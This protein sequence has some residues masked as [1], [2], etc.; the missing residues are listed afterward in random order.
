MKRIIFFITIWIGIC[1]VVTGQVSKSVTIKQSDFRVEK[2]DEYEKITLDKVHYTTDIVGHPELPVDVLSFVIPIDAQITG[3]NISNMSKQKLS[4]TYNIY[5]VQP[6]RPVSY[7]KGIIYFNLPDSAIYN[8]SKPY[9]D[10]YAEIISDDIY[11]GYRVV[12]VRSYPVEYVPAMRELYL[13]SFDFSIDY[14]MNEKQASENK[15]TTQT[16]SLYRYEKNKQNIKFRVEN[17]EVVDGYDTKVQKILQ[18]ETVVYDFSV[19]SNEKTDQPSKIATVSNTQT[20]DYIIITNNALKSSFQT[21]ANWKTRKGIFT[22]IVT[23][24]EIAAN[25]SGVDLQ[26]KIRNYLLNANSQWGAGLYVLLGGGIEIVP[27]RL[28]RGVY[29]S[30]SLYPSD[31]YYS[32]STSW[33][34]YQGN[35]YN[36]NTSTAIINLLG[37][38]PVNNA[39][40]VTIYTNKLITYEK[41]NNL[42]DLSYLKNNLYADAYLEMYPT[43]ELYNFFHKTIKDYKYTYVPS[44]INN[45]YLCDNAD[46]SGST[47]RYGTNGADCSNG[48]TN[49]DIEF[50]PDNFLSCLSTGAGL[51]VGKFHFIYHLDHSGALGLGASF[52]DKNKIIHALNDIEKI[53][54][55]TSYQIL[56]SSGC[57]PAD[58][59]EF[60]GSCFA[61]HHL[62]N[63]NGGGVTFIGNAD[64][65]WQSESAVQL[66]N[67]LDAIYSTTGYPSLGRY[68]IG[69]AYQNVCTG[70]TSQRWRLHL[71]G[72]PEMQVWTDVP[73]TFNNA[74]VL[75]N[76]TNVTVNTGGISDCTIALTSLDNGESYFDVAHN[77]SSYTF[78]NVTEPCN[79]T[80]T[81]HNYIPYLGC[82]T[83]VLNFTNQTVTTDTTIV[84]CGNIN[85]QN[86]TVTNGAKLTLDA[87]GEVNIISGFEVE[88]GSE[89]EITQ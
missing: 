17:P 87:A 42:G 81:K 69:S 36:G 82:S 57:H 32:T 67:F 1:F 41:A 9:P 22:V 85:V 30:T 27:P 74:T 80:I 23:T 29:N 46:C 3:I 78:T 49:G 55:G 50:N 6:P 59:Y 39:Q 66:K 14:S 25:Y 64:V 34:I 4:G 70:T 35:I 72:D 21:L 16:Q 88:L 12:T 2:S 61:K 73:Q 47:S 48:N 28:I 19:A 44:H 24:E 40:E 56:L 37:R 83:S 76:G 8:S 43:G 7:D 51:G 79:V 75:L 33:S 71:I 62:M 18:G 54:N 10:K 20:P 68:D 26:E 84:S 63:P 89:F 38:I 86:V 58:F 15:F 52:K 45:K 5:P 31:R 53:T 60:N 11:L 13:Y 65:G 77:V